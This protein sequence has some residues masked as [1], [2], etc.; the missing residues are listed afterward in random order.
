MSEQALVQA[1]MDKE[2]RDEV[3]EIYEQLGLD[4]PTAIR[5]FFTRTKMVRG[6]PFD[7]TLPEKVI[8]KAE[9]AEKFKK[10]HEAAANVPEI[11]LDEINKV[12][13]RAVAAENFKKM[14]EAAADVPEMSLDEINEEI[15]AAR[16]ERKERGQ[17]GATV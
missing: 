6:I 4:I 12:F 13:A 16:R 1:R 15:A 7:T 3:A 11:S 5:M 2:L 10:I 14:R 8:T 9:A 17:K